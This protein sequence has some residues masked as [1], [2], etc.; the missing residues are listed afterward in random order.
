MRAGHCEVVNHT[1]PSVEPAHDRSHN[2]P[3]DFCNQEQVAIPLE[4]LFD[5]GGSIGWALGEVPIV[6][7][8]GW[9]K[10]APTLDQVL[11]VARQKI[12]EDTRDL[13]QRTILHFGVWEPDVSRAIE[14]NLAPGDVFVDVGCGKGRVV[15][16]AA[17][18]P[19]RRVV[20]IA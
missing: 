11:G 17:R 12:T 19:L 18:R 7:V 15:C 16:C 1:A 3:T 6:I 10:G 4:L 2:L 8:R 14:A 5:L 13:I 20:G 9:A